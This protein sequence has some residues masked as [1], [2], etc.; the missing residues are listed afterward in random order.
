[1]CRYLFAV[2]INEKF[3]GDKCFLRER[4]MEGRFV[5]YFFEDGVE[6]EFFGL[7]CVVFRF[8]ELVCVFMLSF[9]GFVWKNFFSYVGVE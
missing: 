1:M 4:F 3:I 6:K 2:F 5:K 8:L 7:L 9:L